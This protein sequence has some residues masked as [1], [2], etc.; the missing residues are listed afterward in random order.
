MYFVNDLNWI[1]QLWEVC[2]ALAESALGS[3]LVLALPTASALYTSSNIRRSSLWN[4]VRCSSSGI[5]L[6]DIWSVQL[7]RTTFNVWWILKSDE[8]GVT[9]RK[10]PLSSWCRG[11]LRRKLHGRSRLCRRLAQKATASP[12]DWRWRNE[13]CPS[14]AICSYMTQNWALLLVKP[15][16]TTIPP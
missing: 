10:P 12:R 1:A 6:S 14:F 3:I 2:N 16:W 15:P 13:S 11:L 8:G 7:A 9:S 4:L 5:L